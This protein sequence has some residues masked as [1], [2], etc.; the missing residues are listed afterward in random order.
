MSEANDAADTF[1]C[2]ASCGI[3]EIDDIKL[4]PCD[5]CDLVRYCSDACREDHKSEHEEACNKR[6]AELRDELLFKQPDSNHWGD[7]PIC[8]VPLPLDPSRFVTFECCSKII[9]NGC[10]LAIT[11]QNT[12]RRLQHSCPFCREPTPD[13]DEEIENL[14]TKRI[15]ANDPYA[16]TDHGKRQYSKGDYR[17]AFENFTKAADLGNAEANNMLSVMYREGNVVGKDEGKML[18]HLEEA[19]IGGHPKARHNLGAHE[20]KNGNAEK[21]VK[22]FIIAANLGLDESIKALMN[23]FRTGHVS[24]EVLAAAFRAHKAAVD[25]TKSPQRELEEMFAMVKKAH[26]TARNGNC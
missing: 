10:M 24:K 2:C 8:C 9:C 13:N 19:A 21:A 22:H 25:A 17:S 14:V 7:C 5:D 11:E 16:M 12:R 23:E 1:A 26:D 15:E 3:T 20:Y 6:A 4:V 18:Y